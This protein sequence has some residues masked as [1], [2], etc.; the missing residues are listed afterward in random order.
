[1]VPDAR[2]G[3]MTRTK[4]SCAFPYREINW[5]CLVLRLSI[6]IPKVFNY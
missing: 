4:L 1:M 6:H 2:G 5:E 3:S